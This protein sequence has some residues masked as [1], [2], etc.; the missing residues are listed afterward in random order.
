VA[1]TH[2]KGLKGQLNGR[3][4]IRLSLSSRAAAIH[5]NS[6]AASRLNSLA[7]SRLNSLAAIHPN[8]QAAFHHSNP[9]IRSRVD[10]RRSR[11]PDIRLSSSQGPLALKDLGVSLQVVPRHSAKRALS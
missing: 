10:I 4:V 7:A 5:R 6:L 1:A 9:V 11:R 3:E 2:L 8:S